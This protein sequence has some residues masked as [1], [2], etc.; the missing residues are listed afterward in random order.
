M[1]F[2][3]PIVNA[4]DKQRL[5]PLLRPELMSTW[6]ILRLRRVLEAARIVPP[7]RIPADVVTMNSRVRIRDLQWDS[8]ETLTLAYPESARSA[9]EDPDGRAGRLS[10]VSPLGSALL[11]AR[12]GQ[13]ATWIGPRG[14][15]RVRVEALE[16][17]PEKE[18]RYDL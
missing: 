1:N 8:A 18:G 15:R 2:S 16:F 9:P 10:V 13:N 7:E 4:L 17:Q 3:I 5:Q 11:G 14:P 6:P 12:V